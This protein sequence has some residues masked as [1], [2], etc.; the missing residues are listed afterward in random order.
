MEEVNEL[1]KQRI[2]KMSELKDQDIDPYGN[3]FEFTHYSADIHSEYGSH[4]KTFEI[5]A[6]G[7]VRVVDSSGNVL[8]ETMTNHV[9]GWRRLSRPVMKREMLR[10]PIKC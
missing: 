10:K 2:Q 9:P 8:I 6:A 1:I 5:P 7:K 4:D 3:P